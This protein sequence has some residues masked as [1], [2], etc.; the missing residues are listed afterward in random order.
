MV[1]AGRDQRVGGRGVAPAGRRDAGA[2]VRP[3]PPGTAGATPG[4]AGRTQSAPAVDQDPDGILGVSDRLLT[5]LQSNYQVVY[6]GR[7]SADDRAALVVEV[8]R[9]D[10]GLAARFWLDAATKL[11]LRREIFASGAR[12]ISEDAFTSL[13]LGG[14]GLDGMPAPAAAPWAAQLDRARLA[15]LRVQGLA[16]CP[17]GCPAT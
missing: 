12:M 4:T 5:L 17:P 9:P 1:G 11:P 14:R 7:G 6:A 16:D 10:G 8:R 15:A 13:E 2:G 3:P